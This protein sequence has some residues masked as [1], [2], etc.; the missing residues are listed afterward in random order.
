MFNSFRA[1]ST[2]FSFP[3][4]HIQHNV[5][6]EH[7]YLPGS[8]FVF[9]LSATSL[10]LNMGQALKVTWDRQG[11]G[12]DQV[13]FHAA[14]LSL[15]GIRGHLVST[16][17]PRRP[18]R[19]SLRAC[20]INVWLATTAEPKTWLRLL[21]ACFRHKCGFLI[22]WLI[23]MNDLFHFSPP[24]ITTKLLYS[25]FKGERER[26]KK[27]KVLTFFSVRNFSFFFSSSFCFH[28]CLFWQ[29]EMLGHCSNCIHCLVESRIV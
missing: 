28:S 20:V 2:Q 3:P 11:G 10:Y 18:V 4:L 29:S 12:Q 24:P 23:V 19:G 17:E 21:A 16:A 1:Y 14:D 15:S 7:K 6:P 25:A 22:S 9:C 13:S 5:T 26:K 27:K 8:F